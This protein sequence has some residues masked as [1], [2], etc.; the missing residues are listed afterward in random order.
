ME[1]LPNKRWMRYVIWLARFGCIFS[2][3][4][5]FAYLALRS[6]S[7]SEAKGE[8]QLYIIYFYFKFAASAAISSVILSITIYLR[9][10]RVRSLV[11]VGDG[12]LVIVAFL[13]SVGLWIAWGL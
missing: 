10:S 11:L 13:F 12:L 6:V 2:V 8:V 5:F 4:G 3:A 1:K 9:A 7:I